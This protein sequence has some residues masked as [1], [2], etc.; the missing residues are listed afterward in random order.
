MKIR[1]RK[2]DWCRKWLQKFLV[3]ERWQN[4]N[5]IQLSRTPSYIPW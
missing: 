5:G 3:S 4:C 2:A 1:E